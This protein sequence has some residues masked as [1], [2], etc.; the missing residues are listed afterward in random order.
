MRKNSN[1]NEKGII[2]ATLILGLLVLAFVLKRT[3]G[4]IVGDQKQSDVL[5]QVNENEENK[6]ADNKNEDN[7]NEDN[8]NEDSK[9][10]E[11]KNV[12]YKNED[13]QNEDNKNK[14]NKNEDKVT[15][16]DIT[17]DVTE[18]L[19]KII[20]DIC[21]NNNIYGMSYS[22]QSADGAFVWSHCAGEME[23]D[24]Q[25]ALASV[26]KLYTTAIILKLSDDG[27]INLDDTIDQY[28]SNDI[29]DNLHIYEGVDYSHQITVR[30]LM[31]HTSGLPD[32]FTEDAG[33]RVNIEEYSTQVNDIYYDFNEILDRTKSMSPHF[34]PGTEGKAYYSD[35]N[36]QLLGKII[37]NI[38]QLELS[39]AYQEYI[40]TPLNIHNTYLYEKDMK[41]DIQPIEFTRGLDGR[42]LV[43]A[44]EKSTGGLVSTINDNMIFLKAFFNG[45]LFGVEHISEMK[46][47]NS[48]QFYPMKYGTGLMQCNWKYELIGHSGSLGTLA[49]YCPAKDIYI[50]GTVN[51][52]KTKQSIDIA[53]QLI[54]C[55]NTYN[56]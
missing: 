27:E 39:E 20:D 3:D 42:P 35:A 37:E 52:C 26:T 47:Y 49:F 34:A 33:D 48:I 9:N 24:A 13:N 30:Q 11:N 54:D 16:E 31:S 12:E 38:T 25:F 10:E 43:N 32:Y 15:Q 8:K 19:N 18:R 46:N 4:N 50:V 44:S 17:E 41:W 23:A 6:N 14:N 36:F 5:V 2:I 53:Y 51:N 1:R 29:V 28:L 7:Q 21:S 22:I 45:E 55:Y 40:F 56:K